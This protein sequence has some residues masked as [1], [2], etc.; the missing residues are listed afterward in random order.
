[1]PR[2]GILCGVVGK[3]PR[4]ELESQEMEKSSFAADIDAIILILISTSES[5]NSQLRTNLCDLENIGRRKKKKKDLWAE[6][7]IGN[8][9]GLL[10]KL[11]WNRPKL[12]PVPDFFISYFKITE[13][14]NFLTL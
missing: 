9:P 13:F 5:S 11:L 14:F 1:M 12:G 2:N 4:R 6:L 7:L 10:C 8:R 3:P